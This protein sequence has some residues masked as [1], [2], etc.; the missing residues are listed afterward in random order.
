MRMIS[1]ADPALAEEVSNGEPDRFTKDFLERSPG[2]DLLLDSFGRGLFI[3]GTADPEWYVA[4]RILRAPFSC[5]GVKALMP[6]MCQQADELVRAL[7]RDVGY[8]GV[9]YI[10]TWVTKMA[11]ETIAVCGLGTSLGCFESSETPPFVI[12]LNKVIAGLMHLSKCP[13]FLRD[14]LMPFRSREFRRE[15][16][17]LRQ[18]C[19]EL[20]ERRAGRSSGDFHKDLLDVMLLDSDPKSGRKMTHDMVVDNVL[21]FL[22]AGQ[23]STAAAMAS[24]LCYLSAQPDSKARLVR[25]IDDVVGKGELQWTHLAQMPYLDSCI[26]ETLRLVPPALGV[27]RYAKGDQLL[28]K[29]WRIPDGM[30]VLVLLGLQVPS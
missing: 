27:V 1:V 21:T 2:A 23:D 25:E 18:Y 6:L 5:K 11:L 10:D 3:A 28:G 24:C 12:S 22:F 16:R 4:H 17:K 26:K 19:L 20:I 9:A 15:S 30:P 8:G 7:Q 29:K 13:W 14:I